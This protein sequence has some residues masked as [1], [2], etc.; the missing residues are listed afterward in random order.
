M[1]KQRNIVDFQKEH[2]KRMKRLCFFD[3]SIDCTHEFILYD[4]FA[5]N[6]IKK[7]RQRAKE[8][9]VSKLMEGLKHLSEVSLPNN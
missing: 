7:A 4:I 2:D 5:A 1:S 6:L 3:V 9:S 8:T